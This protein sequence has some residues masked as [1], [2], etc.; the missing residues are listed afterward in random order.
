LDPWTSS[1]PFS[2]LN[3]F[4]HSLISTFSIAVAF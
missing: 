1:V 2:D 3:A 4:L